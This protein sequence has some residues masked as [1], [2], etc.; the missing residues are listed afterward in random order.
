MTSLTGWGP[1]ADFVVL[2]LIIFAAVMFI[3]YERTTKQLK[4]TRILPKIRK[5]RF[6]KKF[7]FYK[8]DEDDEQPEE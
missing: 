8:D 1:H 4:G 3:H 5:P 6:L 7:K 2:G